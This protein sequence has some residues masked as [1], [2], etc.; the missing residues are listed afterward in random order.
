MFTKSKK[1]TFNLDN[2]RVPQKYYRERNNM[3]GANPGDV[4]NFS[5]IHYCSPNRQSHPAQKPEGLI[6]RM[7]LASSNENDVV[8]DPFLVAEQL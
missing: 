1:F 6:K 3:R 2:V 7:V 8:L 5:H 4:W